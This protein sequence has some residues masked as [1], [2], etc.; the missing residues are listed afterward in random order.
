MM[1]ADA[2]TTPNPRSPGVRVDVSGLSVVY[3]AK[4]GPLT[5]V[6]SM[7]LTIQPGEFVS[8]VGPSGCGKSTVLKAISGLIA[9]ST[10]RIR[11]DDELVDRKPFEGLGI[12][13]QDALLLDWRN[14]LENVL[15]QADVRRIPRSRLDD[16]ARELLEQVGLADFLDRRP[17]ELSGGMRQRVGI[18]RALVHDPSLLLM[19]EPFGA[20]DALTRDKM[21]EDL[22]GL[23]MELGMTVFFVTHSIPEAV[24]LSDRVLVMSPRPG[25]LL[26][27]FRIQ[28]QRPRTLR[29]LQGQD[30]Y[31]KYVADI[32]SALDEADG[33]SEHEATPLPD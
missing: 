18:C 10:G 12:V 30:R 22:Q 32:R 26:G 25:R 31:L 8:L 14:V 6:E 4:Q 5:A 7:D 3:V 20:L 13:F 19:D 1:D 28:L 24:L 2:G 33:A 16:R 15:L 11:I 9:P 17:F 29:S 21:N 27:D 23:W